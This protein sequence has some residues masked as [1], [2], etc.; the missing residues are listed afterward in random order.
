MQFYF[1]RINIYYETNRVCVPVSKVLRTAGRT[2]MAV[3]FSCYNMAPQILAL[4]ALAS[5]RCPLL[6][7][8]ISD[9]PG[10]P[11]GKQKVNVC[12]FSWISL[13][14]NEITFRKHCHFRCDSLN[15]CFFSLLWFFTAHIGGDSRR[16]VCG[17]SAGRSATYPPASVN[18]QNVFSC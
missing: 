16:L 6:C 2:T 5:L 7:N 11:R 4:L 12:H 18:V 15:F 17:S 9:I 8:Y 3:Y 10:R 1:S 14:R 13:F